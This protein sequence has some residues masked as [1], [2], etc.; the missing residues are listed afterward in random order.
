MRWALIVTLKFI[1]TGF[2]RTAPIKIQKYIYDILL[3]NIFSRARY[4]EKRLPTIKTKRDR[5]RLNS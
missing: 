1:Q 2:Y 5:M 3:R 4:A